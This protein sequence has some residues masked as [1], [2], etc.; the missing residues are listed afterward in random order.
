MLEEHDSL[1]TA[2]SLGLCWKRRDLPES[3]F[4]IPARKQKR[5]LTRK[6]QYKIH[7]IV[8]E[9]YIKTGLFTFENVAADVR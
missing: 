2:L 9:L 6:H 5:K 4:S 3:S 1:S 8:K 7:S